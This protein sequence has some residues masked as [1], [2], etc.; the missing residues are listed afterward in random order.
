MERYKLFWGETHDNTYQA[1]DPEFS[2]EEH[3]K[4]AAGHLDFYCGAYYPSSSPAFKKGGHPSEDKGK[5][6]LN[7]EAWKPEEQIKAEWSEVK[8]AIAEVHR[9]GSFVIFPGFEWQGDGTWGDHNVFFNEDD[10]PL[11]RI[12]TLP[13]LYKALEHH[14]ALAIPHHTAYIQGFRGKNWD[15]HDDRLSPFMEIYSIHGSSE[16]EAFGGGLRNNP[17]LGP[18]QDSGSLS[19][20]LGQGRKLGIIASTDNW[21]PLPGYYGRG[22]AG[23]WAESLSRESLWDAFT[24]RRV[25]GVTGDRIALRFDLDERP[26]GSIL[27]AR[28]KTPVFRVLV[29]ALDRIDYIDFIRDELLI[30][31]VSP[32]GKESLTPEIALTAGQGV[33][34]GE[35][36]GEPMGEYLLRIEYGWGP[37]GNV[38]PLMPKLW[39]GSLQI[40]EGE[41]TEVQP[42]LITP[43]QE[44]SI[45]Q[46]AFTFQGAVPQEGASSAV[47]NGYVIKLRGSRKSRVKITIDGVEQTSSIEGMC[48]GS[49]LL[50]NREAI[51]DLIRENFSVNA[52]TLERKDVLFGMA[53]KVKL[54]QMLPAAAC[55]REISFTDHLYDGRPHSYRVRVRQRNGQLAWSSP[56]WLA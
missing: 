23:V 43:D 31:R 51:A 21:G 49:S 34:T 48:G 22:L 10:P 1:P 29:D 45:H 4:R 52:E 7:V 18:D 19:R 54:H 55:R 13:E 50:W 40:D 46:G 3:L 56:I 11:Y 16:G 6:P 25:Y 26:M 28:S 47:K 20:A 53:Y 15:Y 44:Y 14:R 9:E 36:K 38:L 2:M 27:P 33:A 37:T 30:D 12:D 39:K 32:F 41:I 8:R 24:S 35:S 5:Q 42:C 17:F